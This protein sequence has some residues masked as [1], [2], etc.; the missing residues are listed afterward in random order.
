MNKSW[1]KITSIYIGTVIGA[2]FAS[3][4][5]IIEFF[6]VYGFKGIYGM[7]ISGI[8]FV[9]IGS[10][11]LTKIYNKKVKNFNNLV[12]SLFGK[13]IGFVIDTIIIFSLYTGFSVMTA[14]SGAIF[15]EELGL[16]FNAG[17]VVMV[18]F[19]F[20]VFLFDLEGLS[21]INSILVP[22]LIVGIIFISFY[23]NI[24]ED[25]S[26]S[27]IEGVSCTRKG[28][29]LSSSL[30]YVGSNSLIIIVVF[31]SLLPM[32]NSKRT[33][34]LG[35]LTGGFILSILGI[36]ILT[37]MLIYYNEVCNLDI[38]MLK[39]CSYIGEKYRKLYAIILWIAMFTTALANGFGFMNRIHEE[40]NRLLITGL[41]CIS[42]LPLAKL[43]FSNLIG[44]LYPL[45]GL[46]G[47]III[48]F[49]LIK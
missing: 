49:V 44:I 7:V 14:G 21:F 12:D 25:Y 41:F 23:L 39:I 8:L 34:I 4:R 46:I 22:L 48:I 10:L 43:G 30:L 17:T 27:N 5:E 15:K 13:K 6:G 33:A 31:S 37:S 32:I 47:F 28:N 3:G 2:G 16:S 9:L 35:G 38:P 26:F 20:I 45:S 40:K 18:V 29:F 36:F 24:R 11:L 1:L 42:A 19:S